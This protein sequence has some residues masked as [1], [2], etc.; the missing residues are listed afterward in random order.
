MFDFG[1]SVPAYL[2]NKKNI[3]RLILLTAAFA[4]VFINIYAPFGVE[5][6][7]KDYRQKNLTRWEL[8]LYSSVVILTGVMVVVISRVIMYQFSKRHRVNYWGYFSTILAEVFFMALVYALFE[9]FIL[10]EKRFFPDLLKVSMQNTALVLLLPYSVLWLYF[11]WDDKKKK[12]EEMA[13]GQTA[14]E[15]SQNMFSFSD[16]KGVLRLSLKSENLLYLESSDNY[17]NIYY[18]NKGKVSHFLLRNSLKRLEETFKNSDVIRCHRS[19]MVNYQK[20]KVIRKDKD[21]LMLELDLPSVIDLPVS[22]TYIENVMNNF[23]KSSNPD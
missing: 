20:V 14:T 19:Y 5:T 4:L 7:F 15:N 21:G 6:W 1:Q 16:E 11:S 10:H 13:Q 9:K 8:L 22:K 17:V 18:L 3:T 12:L 2:T 23:S